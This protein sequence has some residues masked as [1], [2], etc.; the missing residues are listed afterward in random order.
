[1]SNWY[2]EIDIKQY[3]SVD[4]SYVAMQAACAGILKEFKKVPEIFN[5][6]EYTFSMFDAVDFFEWV[7]GMDEE[8]FDMYFDNE[9]DAV[10][11]FNNHLA[12]VYDFC[13]EYRVWCGL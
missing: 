11:E 13:D 1:M 6:E 8:H 7:S 4:V 12:E 9:D 2:Y 5:Q 10:E 3:L